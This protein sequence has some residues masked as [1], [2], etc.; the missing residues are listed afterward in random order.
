VDDLW[1]ITSYFNPFG[2]QSRSA[3]FRA[4]RA[5]LGVPLAAV[6]L[7]FGRVPELREGDADRLLQVEGRSVLWQKER[8]LNLALGQ[9]PSTCRYVAWLD[10][11]VVFENPT[12]PALAR[13]ALGEVPLIQP[14]E[15]LLDLGPGVSPGSFGKADVARERPSMAKA[16]ADRNLGPDAAP[17]KRGFR[18]APGHAWVARREL[19]AEVGL[20]EAMI[21]GGGDA[22]MGL[23]ALGLHSEVPEAYAMSPPHATHYLAWAERYYERVRGRL[24][25]VKGTL[26]HLWHGELRDRGY[27]TRHFG[28]RAHDFDPATDLEPV[29]DG[30][31]QWASEKPALHRFVED[32][33]RSRREDG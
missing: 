1:A 4:F 19:L 27:E 31:W 13:E 26:V 28:L 16:L 29:Q 18:Y 14:H 10:C 8:L 15:R 24:G 25:C 12:W 6:E 32:Q 3:N 11:D 23:A 5:R 22:V 17:E 20:Y 30:C 21:V 7:T 2:W 9:L 33:L